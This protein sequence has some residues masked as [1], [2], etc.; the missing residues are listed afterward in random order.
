MQALNSP[1]QLLVCTNTAQLSELAAI[2]VP[3]LWS[4]PNASNIS[5]EHHSIFVMFC[6]N[7]LKATQLSSSCL[8]LAL[9]YLDRF[10]YSVLKSSSTSNCEAEL[11]TA[12]LMLANKSLDDNAYNNHTWSTVSKIPVR[13]LNQ[14]ERDLLVALDYKINP[15]PRQFYTWATQCQYL[16]NLTAKA[17]TLR[18][19]NTPTRRQTSTP[20]LVVLTPFY[21][22]QSFPVKRSAEDADLE[23][24]EYNKRRSSHHAHQH[25]SQSQYQPQTQSQSQSQV[26]V[27]PQI[28]HLQ[29]QPQPLPLPLPQPQIIHHLAQPQHYNPG[30]QVYPPTMAWTPEAI[31][32]STSLNMC[33][34][35]LSWTSASRNVPFVPL[36]TNFLASSSSFT[37]LAFV[38]KK[39]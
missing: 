27:Q 21:T 1:I 3:L 8:I 9:H 23:L 19:S 15:T 24:S 36:Y 37:W 29:P 20:K 14:V 17:Q 7:L 11:L 16:F 32:V 35:I 10:R 33:R 5:P 13:K 18:K 28:V 34:P 39:K 38:K 26:Q 4:G 31:M 2:A 6:F 30:Y 22:Q 12:A 25:Q